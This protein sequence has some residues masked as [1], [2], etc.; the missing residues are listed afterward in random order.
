MSHDGVE[1]ELK[2]ADVELDALRQRLGEME[3]ERQGPPIFEDNWIF[4][5]DGSLDAVGSML[6]LRVDRRGARMTFKGPAVYEGR[7]KVRKEVET[8][9]E[10]VEAARAIFESLGYRV[11]RRYQKYREEWLLGSIVVSLDHTPIGD[12]V[13]LEG[14]G[15]ERF[16]ERL[17]LDPETSERRNYLRL[18]ERHLSEHP[19]APPDMIF[20]ERVPD[21]TS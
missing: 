13:E 4:D 12:F 3:A 5:V 11:V 18:Y 14:E 20:P 7:V 15:C 6:R 19:D 16:A 2:F 17:G 9:V 8:G 10:Q 1:R 21:T